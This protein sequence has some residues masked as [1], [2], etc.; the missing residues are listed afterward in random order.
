MHNG[1]YVGNTIAA[2]KHV[3]IRLPNT[4]N[5]DQ[6]V[7]VNKIQYENLKDYDI[8]KTN[9]KNIREQ[10]LSKLKN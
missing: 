1:I 7:K 2:S 8:H 3:Y 10:V 9:P 5:F 4:T 6:L